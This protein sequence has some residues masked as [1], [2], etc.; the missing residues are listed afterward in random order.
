MIDKYIGVPFLKKG[1]TTKGLDCYGLVMSYY[2][3]CLSIEIPDVGATHLQPS[4]AHLEYI[5]N[6]AKHWKEVDKPVEN[7][8]VAMSTIV[9]RPSLVNHFGIIVSV[10]NKLKIL[11][12]FKETNAHL[13]DIDNIAYKSKIKAYYIWQN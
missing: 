12:T 2:R 5:D 11:H 13:V 1:R 6:A 7:A 9:S 8:V 4:L 10:D 3:D